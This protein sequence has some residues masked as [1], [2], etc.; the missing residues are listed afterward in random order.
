MGRRWWWCDIGNYTLLPKGFNATQVLESSWQS[1]NTINTSSVILEIKT[2]DIWWLFTMCLVLGIA[3][4]RFSNP[5]NHPLRLYLFYHCPSYIRKLWPGE[6]KSFAE[7]PMSRKWQGWMSIAWAPITILHGYTEV[8]SW[9]D[10]RGFSSLYALLC[11]HEYNKS[12]FPLLTP[13]KH[14]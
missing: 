9:R 4:Y 1:E 5:Y 14:Q 2:T 13:I 7:N 10:L 8:R 3:Y 11:G 12:I 6:L